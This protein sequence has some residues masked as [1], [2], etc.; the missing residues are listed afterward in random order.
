MRITSFWFRGLLTSLTILPLFAFADEKDSGNKKAPPG[1][2]FAIQGLAADVASTLSPLMDQAFRMVRRVDPDVSL[3]V[4]TSDPVFRISAYPE[5]QLVP[6]SPMS[7][8]LKGGGRIRAD[9]EDY[10][11]SWTK[12]LEGKNNFKVSVG[13]L[14]LNSRAGSLSIAAETLATLAVNQKPLRYSYPLVKTRAITE[15]TLGILD[16]LVDHYKNSSEQS[17]DVRTKLIRGL[18]GSIRVYETR[19]K[20]MTEMMNDKDVE[21][22]VIALRPKPVGADDSLALVR[23]AM[24]GT[25]THYESSVTQ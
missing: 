4:E 21:R 8:P 14:G 5:A 7:A 1:V 20:I 6:I 19:L 22:P 10:V 11:F 12:P 2:S 13:F 25:S 3:V 23:H 17:L 16:R 15:R 9:R 18:E 24:P